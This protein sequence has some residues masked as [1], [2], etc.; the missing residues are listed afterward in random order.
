MLAPLFGW[1]GGVSGKIGKRLTCEKIIAETTLQWSLN[2][3]D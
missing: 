3:E 2:R 1:V